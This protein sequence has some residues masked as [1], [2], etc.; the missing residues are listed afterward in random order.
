[1]MK[2]VAQAWAF[3]SILLLPNYADLTSGAGDARMRSPVPLTG[4]ALAQ[5]SD[6]LLVSLLFFGLMALLR[7]LSAWP[8]IR[9]VL[10]ALL[11]PLLF[12]RNLDVM[13]FDVPNTVVCAIYLSWAGL[14][15]ALI[16]KFPRFAAKLSNAGSTLLAGFAVFALVITFQLARATLWRPGPQAFKTP[17]AAH[18]TSRPRLVWILFDELAYQPTFEARDPTLQLPN[19]DRLRSQSTLYTDMT[20]IA[21]RTTRA[22]PSLLLGRPVTDVTYTANNNYLVKIEQAPEWQV[23]DARDTLFGMAAQARPHHLPSGLVYRILPRA[24]WN[25]HRLLLGQ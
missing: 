16:L 5:I 2:R 11:P 13:P 10:M 3:A 6:L 15:I 22:V 7:S 1:M 18:S 9:W 14:L 17:V 20:P 19:F 25:C 23:F 12:A 4:I 21:Y 8:K 24:G